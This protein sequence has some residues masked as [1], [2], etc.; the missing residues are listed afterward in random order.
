MEGLRGTGTSDDI[1]PVMTV[2]RVL[3]L[4]AAILSVGLLVLAIFLPVVTV[5]SAHAGTQPRESLVAANGWLVLLLAA[6]PL[7]ASGLVSWLMRTSGT[8][9][10]ITSVALLLASLAGFAT[11]VLGIFV[12]PVGILLVVASALRMADVRQSTGR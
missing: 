1:V 4:A 12:L 11:F 10:L 8:A 7:A 5:L 6:L 2:S 3:I 9:A